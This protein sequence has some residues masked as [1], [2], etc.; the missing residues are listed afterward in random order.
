M[1]YF[2]L[3]GN[4]ELISRIPEEDFFVKSDFYIK[5]L[6]TNNK[7]LPNVVTVENGYTMRGGFQRV[8]QDLIRLLQVLD[9][10]L[11]SRIGKLSIGL[12]RPIGTLCIALPSEP[13]R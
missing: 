12:Y 2:T 5:S 1:T 7:G 8:I 6:D 10:T 9:M 4:A 13:Y 3:L 11:N